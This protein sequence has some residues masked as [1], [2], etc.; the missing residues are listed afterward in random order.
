MADNPISSRSKFLVFMD[1]SEYARVALRFACTRAKARGR[2]VEMLFIINPI[3][4]NSIFAV[5]DV[6]K[7]DRRAEV[8]A[9]LTKFAEEAFAM[10]GITP[11]INIREGTPAEEIISC[12][13]EDHA[14]NMLVM[15]SAPA[16]ASGGSKLLS[17]IVSEVDEKLH[18]PVMIVPAHLTDQQIQELN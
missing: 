15:C 12:I 5:S 11:S 10:S 7:K 17:T 9:K 4:Y 8:E 18:V 16:K 13:A 14:I 3:E 2:P 6:M 1:E